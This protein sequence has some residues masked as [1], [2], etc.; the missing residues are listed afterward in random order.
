[1]N[2]GRKLLCV[3]AVAVSTVAGVVTAMPANASGTVSIVS[4][5]SSGP[6]GTVS[7][8]CA[9]LTT[10]PQTGSFN[11]IPVAFDGSAQATPS[12]VGVAPV[13]TSILCY[14]TNGGSGSAGI[15][16]PGAVAEIAGQGTV[17]RLATSPQICAQVNAAFS[18]GNT[19]P[20]HT[21]CQP[22]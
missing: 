17:Q 1:M 14:L 2:S 12:K 16:T 10:L 9:F 7:G 20:P 4:V 8:Q 5:G 21:I 6:S 19:A 15:T 11:S 13:S 18:D 3:A 22:L